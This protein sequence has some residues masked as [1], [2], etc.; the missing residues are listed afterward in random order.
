MDIS[1]PSKDNVSLLS[2]L[3]LRGASYLSLSRSLD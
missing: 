2:S 3:A 1:L